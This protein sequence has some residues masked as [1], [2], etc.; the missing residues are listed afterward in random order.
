M[1]LFFSRVITLLENPQLFK[2]SLVNSCLSSDKCASI[3]ALSLSILAADLAYA[4]S[5]FCA[6]LR[7]FSAAAASIY[8]TSS[9]SNITVNLKSLSGVVPYSGNS[10]LQPPNIQLFTKSSVSLV[11]VILCTGIYDISLFCRFVYIDLYIL[12]HSSPSVM[13]FIKYSYA[14]LIFTAQSSQLS[15]TPLNLMP[16]ISPL[17]S[18]IIYSLV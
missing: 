10:S 1:V 7:S 18:S 4:S 12:S 5:S 15:F 11:Y 2:S 8:S 9:V 13:R 3:A 14:A 17:S 16:I 6:V